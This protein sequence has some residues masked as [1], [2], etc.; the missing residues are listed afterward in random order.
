MSLEACQQR[1][2]TCWLVLQEAYGSGG[3]RSPEM[4]RRL[5]ASFKSFLPTLMTTPGRPLESY[6]LRRER[7]SPTRWDR[8]PTLPCSTPLTSPLRCLD[9][10]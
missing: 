1:R 4:S 10:A 6:N 8:S 7:P 9:Q 3:P 5:H 2:G